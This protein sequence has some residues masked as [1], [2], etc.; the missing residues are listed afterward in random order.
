MKQSKKEIEELFKN[1]GGANSVGLNDSGTEIVVANLNATTL[2][3]CVGTPIDEIDTDDITIVF[4]AIDMSP[5]MQPVEQEL[6]DAFNEVMIPG[7]KGG[8]KKTTQTMLVGGLAFTEQVYPFWGGGFQKLEELPKLTAKDYNTSRGIATALY[9][10]M[11]DSLTAVSVYGSKVLNETGTPPKVIVV[12]LSDGAN[13]CSPYD[14]DN[15]RTVADQLSKELFVLAFAGFETYEGV[16]F[17]NIA[18]DTG[19]GAIYEVKGGGS[20]VDLQ[21]KFRHLVN[22]MSSSIIRQSQAQVTTAA[23]ASFWQT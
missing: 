14:P 20:Q 1:Q 13:N 4:F 11:L 8:S 16:N 7:L 22:V 21:R 17:K 6:I 15:V 3:M 10:A 12:V 9:K 18:A 23:S 2:P 19:F 5:S